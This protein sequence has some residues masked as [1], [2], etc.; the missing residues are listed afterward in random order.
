MQDWPLIENGPYKR[1]RHDTLFKRQCPHAYSWQFD[2]LASTYQC[3]DADYTI[4]FCEHGPYPPL[5]PRPKPAPELGATQCA[6]TGHGTVVIINIGE[7]C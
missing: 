6:V 1:E 2:D 4:T 3:V 7:S 5:R